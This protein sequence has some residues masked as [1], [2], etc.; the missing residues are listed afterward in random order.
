MVGVTTF[1]IAALAAA[2]LTA[3]DPAGVSAQS[4]PAG[5]TSAPDTTQTVEV[6]RGTRL[7]LDN[8]AGEMRGTGAVR[9]LP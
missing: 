5:A 2:P 9:R 1:L 4:A 3:Q 7:V 6:T 8:F